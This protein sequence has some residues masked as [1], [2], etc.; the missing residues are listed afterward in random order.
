MLKRNV[1]LCTLAVL[2]ATVSS[3]IFDAD[4]GGPPPE[5]NRKFEDLTERWHV[6]NNLELAYN[7]RYINQYDRI[8]DENFTFFLTPGDVGGGLPEQWGRPEELQYNGLLF[9]SEP[10]AEFPRCKSIQMD[11]LWEPAENLQWVEITPGSAPTEKWY[12]ATIFY[13]FKFEMEPDNTY[14][15]NPG[16]KAQ[17]TVRDAG[18]FEGKASHWQ[19]VEFRDLGGAP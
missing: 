16:A 6:I 14:I 13:E 4:E 12:T 5:D 8:L 10:P 3:C 19:L 1:L 11:V 17:F 15:A 7:K 9:S 2:V 18:P